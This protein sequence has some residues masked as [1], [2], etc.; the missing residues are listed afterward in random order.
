M[1]KSRQQVRGGPS[2]Y[3][4]TKFKIGGRNSVKSA[5]HMTTEELLAGIESGNTRG[6]DKQKMR[7]AVRLRGVEA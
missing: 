5:L 2:T 6:R 4:R 1:P 7:Q 3:S